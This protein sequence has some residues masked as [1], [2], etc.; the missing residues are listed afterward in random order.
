M[1]HISIETDAYKFAVTDINSYKKTSFFTDKVREIGVKMTG[2]K[3]K[4]PHYEDYSIEK[5]R[6]AIEQAKMLH[7]DKGRRWPNTL[8]STVYLLVEKMMEMVVM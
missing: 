2:S 6:K 8:A 1:H 3:H 4:E 7:T 5:V